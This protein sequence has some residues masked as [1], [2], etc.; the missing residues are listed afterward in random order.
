MADTPYLCRAMAVALWDP[1]AETYGTPKSVFNVGGVNIDPIHDTDE[2]KVLGAIEETLS[3]LTSMDWSIMFGGINWDIIALMTGQS[4]NYYDDE[5]GE[6]MPYF[7]AA[8]AFPVKGGKDMHVYLF[9]NQLQKR[10]PLD[11]SEQNQFIVPEIE[12][13]AMRLRLTD[14]TTFPIRRLVPPYATQTALPTD[15]N[16]AFGIT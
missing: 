15:F 11:V 9:K 12:V 2:Q 7:G 8:L 13:K 10:V 16:T 5:G 6:D 3:V 4:G 14:G 1:V